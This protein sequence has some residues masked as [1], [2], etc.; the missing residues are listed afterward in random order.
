M[1]AGDIPE[2]VI[3]EYEWIE[4]G[5]GFREF[6]IPGEVVNRYGLPKREAYEPWYKRPKPKISGLPHSSG[7]VLRTY[8]DAT[9]HK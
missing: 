8:E 1:L 4:E 3:A 9:S 7:R 2:N 6:L 5:K